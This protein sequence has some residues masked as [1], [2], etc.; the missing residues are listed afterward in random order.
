MDEDQKIDD[1]EHYQLKYQNQ[2]F[3]NN[4]ELD[5]KND[6]DNTF[7]ARLKYFKII[8]NYMIWIYSK[9]I[10]VTSIYK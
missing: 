7:N 10:G 9:W 8:L 3:D 2:N 1:N 4:N 6:S 5:M